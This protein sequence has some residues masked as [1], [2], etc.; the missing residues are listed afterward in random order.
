MRESPTLSGGA[1]RGVG[2]K[3]DVTVLDR[4]RALG[5]WDSGR[6][7]SSVERDTG[8]CAAGNGEVAKGVAGD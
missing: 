5:A 3:I 2:A 1:G 8:V 4:L 6:D 7:I